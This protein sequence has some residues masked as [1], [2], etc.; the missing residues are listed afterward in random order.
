MGTIDIIYQS[1]PLDELIANLALV[2]SMFIYLT[3]RAQNTNLEHLYIIEVVMHAY[4]TIM[5]N[6]V[7]TIYDYVICNDSLS[8]D[9]LSYHLDSRLL[10][11]YFKKDLTE[12]WH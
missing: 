7:F 4:A 11:M 10:Q 12:F 2:L 5:F 9:G 1:N 8:L 6:F 3:F